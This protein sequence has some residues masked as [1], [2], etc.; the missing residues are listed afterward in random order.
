MT[1][2][3][4]PALDGRD[5]L[6][7]LAALGL[8]RLLTNETGTQVSLSFSDRTAKAIIH[9]DIESIDAITATLNNIVA[10][11]GD[12][13]AI[14][15]VDDRF[16][17]AKPKKSAAASQGAGQKDPMRVR[18]DEYHALAD[19]ITEL[20]DEAKGW[21]HCLITD[22]ATD[23]Q[24]RVALTPYCAPVGQQ[25]LRSFFATPLQ[26]VRKD[27]SYLREALTAW[28]RV[29]KFTGEYLDHRV[30]RSAADH[31]NGVSTEAGVPGAT[32]L[33]TQALR[34]LRISGDGEHVTATLWHR[35]Q[36]RNLMLW[37]L[38][39]EPLDLQAVATLLDHPAINP[40]LDRT[41][42][43]NMNVFTVAA[44]ERTQLRGPKSARVLVPAKTNW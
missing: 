23:A 30:I 29:D 42:L 5:P 11:A 38:W 20:G 28:R 44:A 15:D 7:F 31:P 14:V 26:E 34:L 43:H 10:R 21:F 3:E 36:R 35:H 40:E 24:Q 19:R 2:I 12:A 13:T 39:T 6:G 33:A 22:L 16:P 17:L 37:P 4:L 8:H 41:T 18:R 1:A 25:S 9:S 27:P 32:W